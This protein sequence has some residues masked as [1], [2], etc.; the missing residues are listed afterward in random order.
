VIDASEFSAF[1]STADPARMSRDEAESLALVLQRA[2]LGVEPDVRFGG[3]ALAPGPAV[4]F[5]L[6]QLAERDAACSPSPGYLAAT[7]LLQLAAIIVTAA[8][9]GITAAGRI[10]T[11]PDTAETANTIITALAAELPLS[12]TERSRLTARLRWLL[13][14]GAAPA[15]LDR[16]ISALTATER[17]AA[18]HFLITVAAGPDI[19]PE[20]VSALT[21]AYRLL[22]LDSGLV[23]RRLHR[24]EVAGAGRPW[25]QAEEPVVVRRARPGRP[26]LAL[27][28]T[29]PEES[30]PEDPARVDVSPEEVTRKL[31]E[32]AAVSALLATIFTDDAPAGGAPAAP[33][34][35]DS[36]SPDS[37]S[38]DSASPD[39]AK[40]DPGRLDV[41]H[42]R[43]LAEL[44]ARSS[45]SRADFA[46][47]AARHGVMPSGALDLINEAAMEAAG[48]LAIRGDYELIVD[49]DT[50]RELL[51]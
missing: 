42:S 38:P 15:R 18:G 17:E 6:D 45:W 44:A 13:A 48:E 43:L 3:P 7:T 30:T 14:P 20:T 10:E 50:L 33:A 31:A 35:P 49:D 24:H 51:A 4:L 32:T 2:G 19:A 25:A 27:P 39:A 36:A 9:P 26:G 1:W 23:C 34:S 46:E 12:V 8:P 40:L 41:T 29:P 21:R 5:R 22:G 37:A 47:L 28:R 16:R 11:R